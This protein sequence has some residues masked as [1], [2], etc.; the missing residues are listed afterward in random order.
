VAEATEHKAE[1]PIDRKR[2]RRAALLTSG[3]GIGYGLLSIAGWLLL[4][5]TRNDLEDGSD[6]GDVYAG[7]GAVG[8]EI[9]G[10]YLLPFAA[11]LFLWF[12]VALRGWI[13][14]TQQRR[15]LLISDVQLVSG[16]VF[17]AVFLVGAA[18]IATSVVVAQADPGQLTPQSLRALAG[19]G[20]TLM[21]VMGV[22]IAAIFVIATASLGMT[23]SVLPRW[24]NIVSYGFGLVLMLT[25]VMEPALSLAFPVWVIAL[26]ILL[27]YH[28]INLRD[29]ELPGF[30]QRYRASGTAATGDISS[31]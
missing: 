17:T 8:P 19:F 25:P 15:N 29:D 12:I 9:A 24:F 27:L 30:A 11:I 16:I 31:D 14:N 18:A 23:T 13:R 26:S 1:P 2:L 5:S 6:L 20:S 10:L 22:R 4:S 3:A 7:D 28:L 21:V